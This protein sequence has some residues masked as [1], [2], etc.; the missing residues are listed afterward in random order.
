MDAIVIRDNIKE[1]IARITG[2]PP[3]Q[4]ADTASYR[5]DLGLDSLSMLEIA[6]NAELTFRIKIPDERLSEIE[7]V[8]DG[9]RVITEY[10]AAAT[11]A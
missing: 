6:V 1:S 9:V 3:G 8:A 11:H 2:I 5:D 4:I 7:T 10:V